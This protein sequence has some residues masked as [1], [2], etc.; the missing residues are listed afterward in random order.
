MVCADCGETYGIGDFPFCP[1]GRIENKSQGFTPYM[2]YHIAE[3]PVMITGRGHR[4]QLMRENKL[5]F[6]EQGSQDAGPARWI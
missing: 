5:E 1:H 6:K 3:E 4:R 2:D